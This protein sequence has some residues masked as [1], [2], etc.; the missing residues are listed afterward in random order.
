VEQCVLF[1]MAYVPL[2]T[3]VPATQAHIL[4]S[5]VSLWFF[6]RICFYVAY[7]INPAYRAFGFDYTIFPSLL[8]LAWFLIQVF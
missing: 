4:P 3:V 6:G 5:L 7:H 1:L 8:A 2:A